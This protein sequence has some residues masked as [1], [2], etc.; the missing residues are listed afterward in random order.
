MNV[1]EKKPTIKLMWNG[2]ALA[3][4]GQTY[5]VKEKLKQLGFRWSS[6]AESWGIRAPDKKTV[7]EIVKELK[8]YAEIE[9]IGEA[10]KEPK[11]V[12]VEQVLSTLNSNSGTRYRGSR[13]ML[14][15]IILQVQGWSVTTFFESI[16]VYVRESKKHYVIDLTARHITSPEIYILKDD[17]EQIM[18]FL[19]HLEKFVTRDLPITINGRIER[20][21]Y[22]SYVV[23]LPKDIKPGQTLNFKLDDTLIN[24]IIFGGG[25]DVKDP[26]LLITL[27][28]IADAIDHYV[29]FHYKTRWET[30]E[31]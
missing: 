24:L 9:W 12:A 10:V 8:E 3:V 27:D 19:E 13:E 11:Q 7:L 2:D 17:Q 28:R 26:F 14:Q 4:F 29:T 6:I 16:R 15:S 21:E 5:Q 30:L 18:V 20:D 23:W 1:N 25:K 31:D 22:G